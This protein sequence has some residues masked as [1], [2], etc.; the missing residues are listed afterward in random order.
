[1]NSSQLPVLSSQQNLVRLSVGRW[2]KFNLV[3]GLGVGVQLTALAVFRSWLQLD[4]F[5][6]TGLAVEVAVINNFLWHA[7]FTWVDR[8]ARRPV[9]SL[10]RLAKFNASNGL[11]SI[12]G[13]LLLMRLVV[14]DLKVNYVSANLIAIGLCSLVNFVLGDRFVFGAEENAAAIST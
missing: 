12:V 6:A 9:Q 4:Y 14:G 2:V 8:P 5:V 11:V 13:N 7:R 3:G 1:M 10:I